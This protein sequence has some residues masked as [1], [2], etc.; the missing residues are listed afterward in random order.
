MGRAH[1]RWTRYAGAALAL[2]AQ[3]T[4]RWERP[5][6]CVAARR[7]CQVV[8]IRLAGRRRGGCLLAAV[9]QKALS[10]LTEMG[11]PEVRATKALILNRYVV[12]SGG[13]FLCRDMPPP[14]SRLPG[15]A[16]MAAGCLAAMAAGCLATPGHVSP[17]SVWGHAAGCRSPWPWIGCLRTKAIRTSTNRC[18]PC[19]LHLKAAIVPAILPRTL[20]SGSPLHAP[21][22]THHASH[23]AQHES[24]ATDAPPHG[25]ECRSLAVVVVCS[26][27]CRPWRCVAYR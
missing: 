2:P 1:P 18:Q 8:L 10:S 5:L 9:P 14:S 15:V 12:P 27:D 26:P 4:R 3:T 17:Q 23:N 19:Q 24:R 25:R 11:F 6:V 7:S 13:P 22:T 20:W 21:R 16:A